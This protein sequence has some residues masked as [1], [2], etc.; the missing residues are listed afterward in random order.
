MSSNAE[1]IQVSPEDQFSLSLSRRPADVLAEAKSAADALIRVIES[2][3]NKVTFNGETYLENDDWILLGRFYG[4]SPR[5]KSTTYVE[6][7]PVHGWEAT[8]EAYREATGQVIAMADGMCLNDEDN[9]GMRPKYE[10]VNE[11]DKDGNKIW[12]KTK[13]GKSYCKGSKKEVGRVPVPLFQL[14]SMA[15]TRATS[16]VLSI[17]LK[18][19]VVLA[20]Y[21]PTP[22][23]EVD[24]TTVDASFEQQGD[25]EP[26]QSV[27]RPERKAET[28][29]EAPKGEEKPRDPLNISENQEKMLYGI[30]F[31]QVK[32]SEN[33]LKAEA[34]R[35]CGVDHIRDIKKV[36]F[37]KMLDVIDPEAKFYTK[38]K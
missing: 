8:A 13:E 4:I 37:Q 27:K 22:A 15:Q 5:V 9:W 14:R 32:L 18:W 12:L 21:K 35:L 25:G 11:L 36:D 3:K 17:V 2:K 28:K 29:T 24:Q 10:W 19:V 34:K 23:E 6:Y 1:I 7:G 20:G 38:S 30:A 31:K 33:E 26:K 16:K